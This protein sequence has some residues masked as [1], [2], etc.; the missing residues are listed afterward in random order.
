MGK[1][2]FFVQK[3][4]GYKGN[5]FNLIKFRTMSVETIRMGKI[6]DDDKRL[7]LLG[8][9]L[10]NSSIDELPELINILKGDLSF[11]GPRP[12]LEKYIP[13]YTKEQFKRHDVKPGLTGLAQV[14]GRNLIS[15]DEKF[16][17]DN[18]Y[19]RNQSFLL[20]MKIFF[21]TIIKV[22]QMEGINSSDNMTMKEFVG[23]KK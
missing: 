20:D 3:R 5:L 2:V 14:S 17:L 8:R 7:T 23:R 13:L 12:L 6:L 18:W 19:V 16:A 10:R 21:K 9:F 1:P 15:W 22:I 11:I 4:P